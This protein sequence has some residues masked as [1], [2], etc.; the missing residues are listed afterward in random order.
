MDPI[1][2]CVAL[3]M[4]EEK[5]TQYNKLY[6]ETEEATRSFSKKLFAERQANVIMRN[7][8]SSISTIFLKWFARKQPDFSA[9]PSKSIYDFPK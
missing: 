1:L 4:K 7:C 9:V 5:L 8:G 3:L 2:H 6:T